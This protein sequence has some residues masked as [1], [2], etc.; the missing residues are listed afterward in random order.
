MVHNSEINILLARPISFRM[1]II[2]PPVGLGYLA[3]AL[4]KSGFN[5]SILDC[6]KEKYDFNDFESFIARNE[7]NIIGLQLFTADFESVKKML[8]MIK[9]ANKKI[10]TIVGGA[11][12]SCTART[13]LDQLPNTDYAFHGE[14]EKGIVDL[15][16][17]LI[18]NKGKENLSHISGLIFRDDNTDTGNENGQLEKKTF[19]NVPYYE[20]NLDKLGLPAWDLIPPNSYPNTPHGVVARK[21]PIAPIFLTRGCPFPCTF[22]GAKTITGRK[23]RSRSVNNVIQE[24]KLLNKKFGI[25][26]IHIEDDNFTLSKPYVK[27][28]CESLILNGLNLP[29]A[30]PN[31]VR[32][33]TLDLEI[34]Q[35]M[36]KSGCYSFAVGI[37]SGSPRILRHMKKKISLELIE[38][39]IDLCSQVGI[40]TTGF[41]IVGYPTET[42]ED[43]LKTI[44]FAKKLKLDRAE[45]ANFLPLPGTEAY[46]YLV[47]KKQFEN[48]NWENFL[49]NRYVVYSPPGIS[50]K[51]LRKLQQKAI[52][53]FYLRPRIIFGIM[54]EIRSLRHFWYMSKRFFETVI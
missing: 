22:C 38:E 30:C 19:I 15:I 48:E 29:W 52:F 47:A 37:E 43:I 17:H 18:F 3:T 46:N 42:R 27:D 20:D 40:K 49:P 53:E 44:E 32:L 36:K 11:H 28:F 26:E 4:R 13:I 24:I 45:F 50:F 23:L 39:K 7:Y 35:L 12:P 54:K 9:S 14:A 51:E 33:D 1:P 41:F 6:A 5:V 16:N 21:F 2:I 8:G 25:R 31:G 34:L 10:V